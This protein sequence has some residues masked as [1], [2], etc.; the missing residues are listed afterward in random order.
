MFYMYLKVCENYLRV[1]KL[2]L[3]KK[4]GLVYSA[5]R[6][7]TYRFISQYLLASNPSG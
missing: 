2:Y 1:V 6:P 3:I 7:I 4:I 5:I